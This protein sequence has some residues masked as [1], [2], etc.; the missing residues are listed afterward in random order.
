MGQ[1]LMKVADRRDN[2][3]RLYNGRDSHGNPKYKRVQAYYFPS[4]AEAQRRFDPKVE[5]PNFPGDWE[6]ESSPADEMKTEQ[7]Y[8]EDVPF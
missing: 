7:Q 3:G 4:L 8:E 1:L 2:N 5:W 6:F